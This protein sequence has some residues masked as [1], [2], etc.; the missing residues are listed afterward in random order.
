MPYD[1]QPN[2]R[3]FLIGVIIILIIAIPVL[4][5]GYFFLA[6]ESVGA[7]EYALQRDTFSQTVSPDTYD[8]GLYHIGLFADFIR[9]PA[10]AI[11]VEFFE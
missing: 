7:T 5:I 9:F 10:P 11:A 1:D 3:V 2:Y 6:F 4:G 8:T